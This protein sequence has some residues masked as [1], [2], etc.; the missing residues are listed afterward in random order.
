MDVCGK[1]HEQFNALL[2]SYGLQKIGSSSEKDSQKG[3]KFQVD[4]FSQFTAS[5]IRVYHSVNSR[6]CSLGIHS[7]QLHGDYHDF[8]DF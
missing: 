4:D 7:K 8:D 3:A 6:F 5:K 2:N 1:E